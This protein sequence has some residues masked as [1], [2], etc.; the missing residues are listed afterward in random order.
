MGEER[1]Q[2]LSD[3]RVFKFYPR[4]EKCQTMKSKYVNRYYGQADEIV[5]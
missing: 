4:N 1:R 5:A 3:I 2:A